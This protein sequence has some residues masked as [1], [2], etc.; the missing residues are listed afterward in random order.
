[1]IKPT[2]ADLQAQFKAKWRTGR[3]AF[4]ARVLSERRL[5][6]LALLAMIVFV[7]DALWLTPTF[8]RLKAVHKRQ[9]VA[10]QAR[11]ALQADAIKRLGDRQRRQ[12]E[13]RVE[14]K[15]LQDVLAQDQEALQQQQAVL[16]PAREMRALLEGLL[17]ENAR[18]KVKG[19]RTLPPQEVKIKSV[20]DAGRQPM[21]YRQSMEIV[22][23]GGFN[24]LV[25]WLHSAENLPKRILWDSV[26]LSADD[27]AVLTLALTVHTFSPDKDALEIAP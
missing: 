14:I 13:A 10:M 6:T 3:R 1:M 21:L 19:I 7:S 27:N 25:R 23:Q 17:E 4:D 9:A 2:L 24:E 26:Q 12:D 16:A 15:R 11:D 22:L 20:L 18:L 8:D 5:L